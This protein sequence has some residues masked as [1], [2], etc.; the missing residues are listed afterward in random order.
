MSDIV[1][2]HIEDNVSLGPNHVGFWN[3]LDPCSLDAFSRHPLTELSSSMPEG[4]VLRV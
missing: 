2:T 3:L 4:E 1:N